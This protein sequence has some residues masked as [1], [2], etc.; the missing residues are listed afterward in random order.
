MRSAEVLRNGWRRAVGVAKS[1][2]KQSENVENGL[3]EV[4]V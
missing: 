4:D 2:R 3:E 1:E